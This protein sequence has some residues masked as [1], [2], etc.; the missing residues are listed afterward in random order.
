MDGSEQWSLR[1]LWAHAIGFAE[2]KLAVAMAAA[3][4]LLWVRNPGTAWASVVGATLG[5]ITWVVA[6]YVFHRCLLH[7]EIPAGAPGW[8]RW[9]ME[10]GHQG[11]HREPRRPELLFVPWW[12][13]PGLLALAY[14]LG[15]LLEG[16]LGLP[17]LALAVAATYA[18]CLVFYEV[19][20]L[21]AHV[22]YR[23]RTRYGRWMKRHHLLHH[24][25]D[26]SVWFGV[27]NPLA[28]MVAGTW[29]APAARPPEP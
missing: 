25:K 9:I 2:M 13:S 24:Y 26:A 7:L 8:A 17:G 5:M 11:H 1:R 6:E 21:A 27:T 23:P 18:V 29:P 19:M 16:Q 10:R 4:V 28:D 14:G 12:A 20:H 22:P 15:V 3:M